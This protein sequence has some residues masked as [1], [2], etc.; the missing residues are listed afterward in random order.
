MNEIS[1]DE[2][3]EPDEDVITADPRYPW[4]RPVN[5]FATMTNLVAIVLFLLEF[6]MLIFAAVTCINQKRAFEARGVVVIMCTIGIFQLAF[7]TL[8][9]TTTALFDREIRDSPPDR[10]LNEPELEDRKRFLRLPVFIDTL[11]FVAFTAHAYVRYFPSDPESG[12]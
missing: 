7:K 3:S 1:S 8:Y 11:F 6:L 12:G 4:L 2:H 9:F 5:V 10:K